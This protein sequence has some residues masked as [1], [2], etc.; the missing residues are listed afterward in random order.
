MLGSRCTARRNSCSSC[1]TSARQ[2]P[3]SKCWPPP[4]CGHAMPQTVCC[5]RDRRPHTGKRSPPTG[6][7]QPASARSTALEHCCRPDHPMQTVRTS[8]S[9][10]C[11]SNDGGSRTRPYGGPRRGRRTRVGAESPRS[12]IR[13]R[14]SCLRVDLASAFIAQD[15]REEANVHIAKARTLAVNIGSPRQLQRIKNSPNLMLRHGKS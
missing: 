7:P 11:A 9:T 1:S 6:R 14:R 2:A 13:P 10:P 3:P 5:A 15:A 8:R 4:K 12:D